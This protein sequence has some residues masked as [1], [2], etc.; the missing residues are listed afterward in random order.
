[1]GLGPRLSGSAA[2]LRACPTRRATREPDSGGLASRHKA[3]PPRARSVGRGSDC[4]ARLRARTCRPS[5]ILDFELGCRCQAVGN[6]V[7]PGGVMSVAHPPSELT[8]ILIYYIPGAAS[9][10]KFRDRPS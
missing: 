7:S 6:W 8:T 5:Y 10:G 4:E 9:R 3:R 2:R 1:M